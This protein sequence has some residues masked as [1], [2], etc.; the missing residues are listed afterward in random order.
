MD[1]GLKCDLE[2]RLVPKGDIVIPPVQR[3]LLARASTF[4]CEP[5][6]HEDYVLTI[7]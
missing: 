6:S 5:C 7:H 3:Y 1:D 4:P 2:D